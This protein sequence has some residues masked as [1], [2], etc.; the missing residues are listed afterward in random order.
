MEFKYERDRFG[1]LKIGKPSPVPKFASTPEM[2][3][4][5]QFLL[6]EIPQT[7]MKRKV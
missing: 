3:K 2:R 4:R 5:L 1:G 7:C 6:K